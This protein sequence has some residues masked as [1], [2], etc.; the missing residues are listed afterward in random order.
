MDEAGIDLAVLSLAEPG[1]Q[2][3]NEDT[4]HSDGD[5]GKRPPG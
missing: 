1:V 3:F 2:V 5:S 4:A